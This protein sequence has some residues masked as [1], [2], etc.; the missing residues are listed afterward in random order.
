MKETDWEED[1]LARPL[2]LVAEGLLLVVLVVGG[3]R[4][5]LLCLLGLSPDHAACTRPPAPVN[6]S[7]QQQPRTVRN[8]PIQDT[9][10]RPRDALVSGV[11]TRCCRLHGVCLGSAA[12]SFY[13]VGGFAV[14]GFAVQVSAG[15]QMFHLLRVQFA[16]QVED[17]C[18]NS[19]LR[20]GVLQ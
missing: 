16:L 7:L 20:P 19:T 8:I 4:F 15:R 2:W 10:R 1:V 13:S 14:A 11:R 12:L 17:G 3:V 18:L 9:D 6:R 5:S